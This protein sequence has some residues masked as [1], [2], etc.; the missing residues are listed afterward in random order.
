M[1]RLWS[2]TDGGEMWMRREQSKLV[3][4]LAFDGEGRSLAS[5]A[6]DGSVVVCRWSVSAYPDN[7]ARDRSTARTEAR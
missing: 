4:E 2:L 7:R 1:V 6:K 3:V 5:A